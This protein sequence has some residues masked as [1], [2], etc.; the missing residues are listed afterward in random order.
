VIEIQALLAL[1]MAAD[2]DEERAVPTL[3]AA[4]TLAHPQGY[5]RVFADEGPSMGAL[6]GRLIATQP[7]R[8]PVAGTVPLAY[9]GRL[10]RA[11]QPN[12]AGRYRPSR[13]G[14]AI[15]T[16]PVIALSERELQVLH[17]L[18]AGKQN[19]E[20]ADELYI[21]RDTVKKHITHILDKVG[22]VN[23]TQAIAHARELGLLS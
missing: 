22:A 11:V 20:I 9:L 7:R 8:Q 23:R 2:G 15:A 19:R 17:L 1:A 6:L 3:A 5:I 4:L 10:A 12:I 21:T 14:R 16:G 18:A 13:P